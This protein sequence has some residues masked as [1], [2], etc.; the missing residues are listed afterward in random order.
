MT[1]VFNRESQ[2][3]KRRELRRAETRAEALMWEHLR[4][5]RLANAK[6]RRQYSVGFYVLDFYC[7]EVQLAVELDGSS[8]DGEEAQTYDAERQSPLKR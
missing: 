6:F 8:H 1:Q 7:P 3:P 5:N 2:E 4:S